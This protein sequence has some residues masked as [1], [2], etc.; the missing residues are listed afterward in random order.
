[1]AAMT[2]KYYNLNLIRVYRYIYIVCVIFCELEII[3]RIK[4][5]AVPSVQ[6]YNTVVHTRA[7]PVYRNTAIGHCS[8]R[9]TTRL[10][11]CTK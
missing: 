9:K 5:F 3:F 11:K 1:M 10:C 6:V 2:V 4:Q 8:V 7:V